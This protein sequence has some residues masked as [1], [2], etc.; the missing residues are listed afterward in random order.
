VNEDS[1]ARTVSR[2][3]N[4]RVVAHLRRHLD[5]AGAPIRQSSPGALLIGAGDTLERVPLV[6]SGTIDAVIHQMTDDGNQVVPVSWGDGEIA[7]LS[8]LFTRRSLAVDIVASE[9]VSYRWLPMAEIERCLQYDRELL[10]L[11]VQYLATRL[12]EV[13]SRERAWLERGVH[14]RVCASLARFM[15]AMAADDGQP[16]VIAAT[17]ESLAARCAV[18]RPRLSKEL[19]RLEEAGRLRLGRGTIEIVDRDWFDGARW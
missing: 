18:S 8:Y 11:V 7:L 1:P 9:E 2:E 17:H 6:V 10:V 5:I 14:E 13:Q 19:K 3:L 16:L 15:A 12:R 4:L